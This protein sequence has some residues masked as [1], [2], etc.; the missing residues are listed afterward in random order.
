MNRKAMT[1]LSIVVFA[2]VSAA[3]VLA[4]MVAFSSPGNPPPL[5][6][7]DGAVANLLKTLGD[8]P[9][10]KTFPARDGT[11]IAYRSYPSQADRVAV[12]V[13]GSSGSSIIMHPLAKELANAGIATY[14]LDMRGHGFSGP[15]GDVAYIGQLEDDVEDFLKHIAAAH[16]NARR[17]LIGVS[18]GGGFVLRYAGGP[19]G[20]QFD[21]YIA[22]APYLS[23]DAG[24]TR[25]RDAS[26]WV[27]VA[28]PRLIALSILDRIGI[29]YFGYLP[30]LG[31]AI[32]PEQRSLPVVTPAYS[33]RLWTNFRT[34]RD[35]KGA[36]ANIRR[37][38]RIIVGADDELFYADKFAPALAPIRTDIPVEI[39]PKVNHLQVTTEP[40]AIAVTVRNAIDLLSSR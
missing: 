31:F 32:A 4:G 40:A 25:T 26:G 3:G 29:R 10:Y 30:V 15:K 24:N 21:A 14:A 6:T 35:W 22:Q 2:L 39:V 7:I 27:S 5:K 38:T 33:Y 18:A 19:K 9:Q 13:H 36:I 1:L 16:P 11:P 23:E 37:P 34:P 8:L 12:L 20:Q 28:I 17:I